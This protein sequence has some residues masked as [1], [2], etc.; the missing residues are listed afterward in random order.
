[1]WWMI[2]GVPFGYLL[3]RYYEKIGNSIGEI[4]FAEKYLGSGGTY[5][6]IK[7]LGI[8]IILFSFIY[9]LGGCDALFKKIEILNGTPDQNI[10]GSI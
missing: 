1:M 3:L 7:L 10:E 9:P 4:G 2:F 6:F 5:T 8:L